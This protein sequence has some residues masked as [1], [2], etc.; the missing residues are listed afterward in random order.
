MS[1][2]YKF[3]GSPTHSCVRAISV[4]G[5]SGGEGLTIKTRKYIKSIVGLWIPLFI[6]TLEVFPNVLCQPRDKFLHFAHSFQ[7]K[8]KEKEKEK[9]TEAKDFL[10]YM[11]R[12]YPDAKYLTTAQILEDSVFKALTA[13]LTKVNL[14]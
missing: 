5:G 7:I 1:F 6:K 11:S 9:E 14:T 12:T 4:G 8:W 2:S 13:R 10:Q 3:D